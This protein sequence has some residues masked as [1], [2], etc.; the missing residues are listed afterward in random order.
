M[1]M[2]TRNQ[3][4]FTLYVRIMNRNAK[5]IKKILKNTDI[6][7]IEK[8]ELVKKF[9]GYTGWIRSYFSR[10]TNKELAEIISNKQS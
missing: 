9:A 3:N 1:E 4:V 8:K 5:S 7:A 10:T 2:C 6:D